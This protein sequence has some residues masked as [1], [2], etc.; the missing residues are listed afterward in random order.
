PLVGLGIPLCYWLII[1]KPGLITGVK[2]IILISVSWVLGYGLMWSS[3][4]VLA[5]VLTDANVLG[6]GLAQV[7]YRT[8]GPDT[9]SFSAGQVI[10]KNLQLVGYKAFLIIL[11]V[12][13]LYYIKCLVK[14]GYRLKWCNNNLLFFVVAVMP[15]VW[16]A[17]VKNHCYVH[18]YMTHKILAVFFCACLCIVPSSMRKKEI[19]L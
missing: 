3:K 10:M 5:S 1:R 16:M 18:S 2:E 9:Q 8:S 4:W 11:I 12:I 15:F 7:L 13:V 19:D 17:V 6:D 14:D